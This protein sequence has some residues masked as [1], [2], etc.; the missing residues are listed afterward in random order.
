M[1]TDND[2]IPQSPCQADETTKGQTAVLPDNGSRTELAD[3]RTE[4]SEAQSDALCTSELNYRRLFESARD[5]ILI[6]NAA[7]GR[8]VDVNPF[9][10]ELLGYSHGEMLGKTVGELSPFKD[11]LSNQAMLERLQKDGYIRYEDLPLET[12][13]GRHIAVEFVSNV[14]QVDDKNVIQCNIRD[15]T[16]RKR[17]MEEANRMA[18]VVRDSNDAITIQD[19][20]GRITAWNRG[21]EQ[22]YGYSEAEALQMTIWQLAPPDK[23]A[24]QKDFNRRIFAGEKVSSFETQRVT[25]DGHVLDVWLTVTKLMDDAG[26][27]IGIAST[28]RDITERKRVEES[29]NRL[30]M[31]VEQAAEAIEITD[32]NATILYVNPAFE[33]TSGYTRAEALGQNPRI[34]KSGKQNAQFYRRMWA[35]L[36]LGKVWQGH[37]INRRK[38]GKLYEEEATISPV[39]D[40]AGK[41]VNYVAVKRD[42]THEMQLEAQIRQSQKMESI[43]TLAGGVAHDFNNILA[44]ISM[45]AGLL[46]ASGGISPALTEYANEIGITVDRAAALTRQ[47]LLFSR[48]EILQLRDLNLNATITNTTKML[49]RILGET[50]EVQLKLAAQPLFVHADAGMLDQVLMNLAVN[51]H[52]AMH[53]GGQL[54]IETSGV[55]LD[56][57]TAAKVVTARPGSFVCLSVSDS[58]SGIPPEILPRIFEPFFTTKAVGKGTG[59]GLAIVFSIVQQHKG[60]INVYSEVGHGTTFRIYLPRL[61]GVTD[62]KI[63]QKMPSNVPH[64]NETILLVEDEP[65]LLIAMRKTL[66]QLGYHILEAPNGVKALSVWQAHRDEIHLLLTDLVMP[67]GMTGIDLAKRLLQEKPKLKVVYMSGYSAKLVGKDFQMKEGANFVSKPFEVLKLAQTI[68]ASLD[69][70]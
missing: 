50:I 4:K 29:H 58:G 42:V 49:R 5:G 44:I 1:K 65:A 18:T 66:C 21:A 68:R 43:G 33:K 14:Y 55:E 23:T 22:M 57:F 8:I 12:R 53:N 17:E 24:E 52:N 64:G 16:T 60:W 6:L 62:I 59:L 63:A 38:D 51:A 20:E 10:I 47:L 56:E 26:K 48:H 19:F 25:K 15:I 9:L 7:T 70:I 30:A 40:A 67:A 69:K 11:I 13:D 46:K 2:C 32:I 36:A 61:S 54:V 28:A 39:R 35:E 31:A 37:F 3:L 41:I 45:Q 27:P 34:L